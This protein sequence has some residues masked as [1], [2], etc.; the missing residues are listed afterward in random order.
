MLL[1]VASARNLLNLEGKLDC[2][3]LQGFR[4]S[5]KPIDVWGDK[6][7]YPAS[8]GISNL[9]DQGRN[10]DEKYEKEGTL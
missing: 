5:L 2:M 4:I 9:L 8:S 3:R 7:T 10:I 6:I 1:L